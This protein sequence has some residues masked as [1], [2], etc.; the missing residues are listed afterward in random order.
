MD[1]RDKLI[2]EL[3]KVCEE[4]HREGMHTHECGWWDIR[5]SRG[6]L[7]DCGVCDCWLRRVA[8]AVAKGKAHL[9]AADDIDRLF[10]DEGE[11]GA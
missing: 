11:A 5:D 3:V 6:F 2:A 4:A 1:A 7:H 10:R 9:A 8:S